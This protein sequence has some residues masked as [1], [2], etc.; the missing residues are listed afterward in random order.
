MK[1]KLVEI[2][3]KLTKAKTILYFN[4]QLYFWDKKTNKEVCFSKTTSQ[5]L[6]TDF[7]VY[8]DS[9]NF[10]LIPSSIAENIS[11]N[12][13]GEFLSSTYKNQPII[14]EDIPYLES[15]ICWLIDKDELDF[16]KSRIPGAKIKHISE[17]LINKSISSKS[18]I[19]LFNI[20]TAIFICITDKNKLKTINRFP[21]SNND[22][23]LYYTLLS[24]K[25]TGLSKKKFTLNYYGAKNDI[26]I[27]KLSITLANC[28]IN[29]EKNNSYLSIIN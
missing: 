7:F 12:K 21:I 15:E 27:E 20:E 19:T 4:Q 17:A 26:F 3:S 5:K 29:K 9:P 22:D 18:D 23:L 28:S 2:G 10:N 24:I 13:K 8:S 25:E 6:P 1:L 11:D 16:I 14:K